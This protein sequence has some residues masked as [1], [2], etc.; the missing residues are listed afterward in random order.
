LQV[1]EPSFN[2]KLPEIGNSLCA[3]LKMVFEAFPVDAPDTHQDV[4]L[5]HQKVE[6]LIQKQLTTVTA[7]QPQ[8]ALE[9]SN[10]NVL[11]SFTLNILKTLVSGTKQYID[12][13]M[14]YLVRVFQRLARE[15]AT[16]S[17]QLARQVRICRCSSGQQNSVARIY[18]ENVLL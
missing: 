13:F 12:K 18:L 9:P 8:P 1:L 2:C 4:K 15:M 11:I 16:T 10:A 5:L 17:A 3:L 6:E 14:M 7:N